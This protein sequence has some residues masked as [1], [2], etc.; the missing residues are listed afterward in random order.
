MDDLTQ[1]RDVMLRRLLAR[2]RR[3]FEVDEEKLRQDMAETKAEVA[4]AQNLLEPRW[5]RRVEEPS[6]ARESNSV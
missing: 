1:W 5:R 2:L 3:S 4:E 6:I